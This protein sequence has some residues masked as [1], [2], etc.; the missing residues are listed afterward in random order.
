MRKKTLLLIVIFLSIISIFSEN[1]K[2]QELK[3]DAKKY[4]NKNIMLDE[5][6]EGDFYFKNCKVVLKNKF[7]GNILLE[8]SNFKVDK[9]GLI[10]GSVYIKNSKFISGDTILN[11]S[12]TVARF[13]GDSQGVKV[14]PEKEKN[15]LKQTKPFSNNFT[16]SSL[17]K[18]RFYIF[19]FLITLFI[20]YILKQSIFDQREDFKQYVLKYFLVGIIFWVLFPFLTLLL[21]I[22]IIGIP[23]WIIFI[24]FLIFGILVGIVL[25]SSWIGSNLYNKDNFVGFI[26]GF[27]SIIFVDFIFYGTYNILK[28]NGISWMNFILWTVIILIS[29]GITMRFIKKL[30]SK[31]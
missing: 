9:N 12:F 29:T 3:K 14:K 1:Q 16:K 20:F 8:N 22:S 15:N 23:V 10:Y 19:L 18:L 30:F 5:E 2:F 13:S 26:L 11:A 7:N 17:D 6:N 25:I 28:F 31:R 27:L 24:L 4:Y 21:L